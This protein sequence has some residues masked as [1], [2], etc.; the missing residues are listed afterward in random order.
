VLPVLPVLTSNQQIAPDLS[1]YVL[2][3][4]SKTVS[5]NVSKVSPSFSLTSNDLIQQGELTETLM[6]TDVKTVVR[7]VCNRSQN[8]PL[9]AFCSS[10]DAPN[11]DTCVGE[12][13]SGLICG[14]VLRG[15]VSRDCQDGRITQYTDV[16][17]TFNW[18]V[19]SHL[20]SS[21]NLIDSDSLKSFVFSV[22][23]FAAYFINTPK[24]AD[25]FEVLKFFF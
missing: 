16:S 1:C 13:G 19:L 3:W 2:G 12:E 24:I 7:A 25:D 18:I 15:V 8:F 21:L 4:R 10:E 6:R 5:D 11:L 22:L 9:G 23:D 14:G 20:D 17:Q